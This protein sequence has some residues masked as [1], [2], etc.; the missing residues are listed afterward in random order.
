MRPSADSASSVLWRRSALSARSRSVVSTT[1][2]SSW[3]A[4]RSPSHRSRRSGTRAC[5]RRSGTRTWIVRALVGAAG[6]GGVVRRNDDDVRALAI[7]KVASRR[8]TD[9]I[10]FEIAIKSD[11]PPSKPRCAAPPETAPMSI[12][13]PHSGRPRAHA[14]R[15]RSAG[16]RTAPFADSGRSRWRA[17]CTAL[18][19]SARSSPGRRS[20]QAA[21]ADALGREG[22]ARC[23]PETPSSRQPRA[24]AQRDRICHQRQMAAIEH[25][26]A[27][28]G[29][30]DGLPPR[31]ISSR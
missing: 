27:A 13:R 14:H 3:L 24:P 21:P 4:A 30:Q 22:H 6:A 15:P 18:S 11:V 1:S 26:P 25:D 12:A 9:R 7:A 10:T 19:P 23:G 28:V 5:S 29:V 2:T 31:A 20:R 8:R 16:A 17:S